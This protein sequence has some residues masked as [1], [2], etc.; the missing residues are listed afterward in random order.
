MKLPRSKLRGSL[1][2]FFRSDKPSFAKATEG[3]FSPSSPQQAAG[4]SAKENKN[5]K[6]S[7]PIFI[8]FRIY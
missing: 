3:F 7:L 4:Y 6:N 5:E 1:A 8:E 2:E